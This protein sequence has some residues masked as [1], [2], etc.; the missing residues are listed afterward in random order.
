MR[1]IDADAL[2]HW[3]ESAPLTIEQ[4]LLFSGI[5]EYVENETV[6]AIPIDWMLKWKDSGITEESADLLSDLGGDYIKWMIAEWR[7]VNG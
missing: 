4:G 3:I 1:L 2:I 5:A 6:D 7:K